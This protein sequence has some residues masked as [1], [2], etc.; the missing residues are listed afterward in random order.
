MSGIDSLVMLISRW[1]N[2]L[3]HSEISADLKPF[4][5]PVIFGNL[6]RLQDGTWSLT[7]DGRERV[8]QLWAEDG[9]KCPHCGKPLGL[10]DMMF[11]EVCY[12]HQYAFDVFHGK[13][14]EWGWVVGDGS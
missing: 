3:P 5:E 9:N 11:I 10:S 1:D 13:E 4:C 8:R 6:A 2:K 12:E 14:V 7:D